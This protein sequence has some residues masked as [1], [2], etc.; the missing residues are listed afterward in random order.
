MMISPRR[1][2]HLAV[3]LVLVLL[4]AGLAAAAQPQL[5]WKV[6]TTTRLPTAGTLAD[7]NGDGLDEIV[8][9]GY[10][11]ML[12]LDGAGK[13]VWRTPIKARFSTYPAVWQRQGARPLIYVGDNTNTMY[14][15]DSAGKQVWQVALGEA[16]NWSAA[17]VADVNGDGKAEVL[18]AAESGTIWAM[19]ALT[20]KEVWRHKATAGTGASISV[21]DLDGDGKPEVAEGLEDGNL[22][23]LRGDGSE[24]WTRKLGDT[25]SSAPV[26]FTAGDGAGRIVGAADDGQVFCVDAKGAELWRRP[27]GADM[28]AS[29]SVGDMDLDGR[30]DIFL[31]T[32]AGV[33]MRLDEGGSVI[34]TLNMQTRTDAAGAIADLDGDGR[35]EYVMCTHNALLLALNNAGEIVWQYQMPVHIAYNATPTFGKVS[36]QSAGRDMAVAGGDS[37]WFF[38]FS[39]PARTGA[40]MQWNGYR[41]S[42]AMTGNWP[43]LAGSAGA[44]A[45][46]TPLDLAWN[47]VYTGQGLRFRITNPDP[48]QPVRA[49]ASCVSPSGARQTA[50]ASIVTRVGELALPVDVLSP[51]LYQVSWLLRG[52]DGKELAAGSR[53][54]T[55]TPFANDRGLAARAV[56]ELTATAA[57]IE[58]TLPL[59]ASALRRQARSLEAQ[60]RAVR[61]AQEAAQQPGAAAQR[62]ALADTAE[63]VKAAQRALGVAAAVRQAAALGEGT[64]IIAFQGPAWENLGVAGLLPD[65]A[66]SPLTISRRVVTGERTALPVNLFNVTDRELHVQVRIEAPAGVQVTPRQAFP[67]PTSNGLV[68]WD[69]L[70]ELDQASAIAVPS[71]ETRQLWLEVE[72]GNAA[73]RQEI[74]VRL[75]ALDG[76]GS[77]DG[78]RR[79]RTVAPPETTVAVSLDVLPF[80]MA[81]S[82]AFRL[83]TWAGVESSQ[84]KDMAAATY[85]LLLSRGNNVWTVSPQPDAVYDLQGQLAGPLDYAKFD[86]A[87]KP[88]LGKDVVLLLMGMP[89]LKPVDGKDPYGSDAYAKAL[90]PY[91]AAL[92]EHLA[93]L[94]FDRQHWAFYPY[95][96]AGGDGWGSIEA[97]VKFGKLVKG[98]DPLARIYADAG[99]AD[100]KMMEVIAPYIDIWCPG[101]NLVQSDPVQF[102]IMNQPGKTV[103]SYN[104]SYNNYNKP[105]GRRSGLKSTDVIP[106]YRV[107][108]AWAFRHGLTGAG[109]WTSTT[110][111]EDLWGR[112]NVE[113]KMLYPGRTAPVTSRRWEAVG[114]GVQDYRLLAALQAKLADAATPAAAKAKIK[115][116]LE[117]SLPT[118]IDGYTDEPGLNALRTEMMDCVEACLQ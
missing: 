115:H 81:P 33:I 59:S 61:P 76:A 47:T 30:A 118:Y 39:T 112:V 87:V 86:A 4:A 111:A 99:G 85:D 18:Q 102:G 98:A 15:F 51:G 113:Y 79:D 96:E 66:A 77:L 35:L 3:A 109:F 19:D 72:P 7:L 17:T 49:E 43:G 1:F 91:I 48:K 2:C 54:L 69:P 89:G 114:E 105:Y 6:N 92:T 9:A 10:Q 31:V 90:K 106:E 8:I 100:P 14:C 83:C 11:E 37:G 34:W 71:L 103:W 108:A 67:V 40:P 78:S 107:A 68:S 12:A 45:T 94:G 5:L 57:Q 74:T 21:G 25:L 110:G 28:D 117:V 29:I 82:G 104:C 50:T 52:G 26:I 88:L 46:I 64:S 65:G 62:Q 93:G 80:A 42:A 13:Q 53:R 97:T 101:V 55:L 36:K 20:G 84:F 116:L 41:G 23:V 16:C 95:D 56:A 63:V 70:P 58:G 27:A 60:D 32:M 38:L 73:G 44:A 22:L 75:L 24:L